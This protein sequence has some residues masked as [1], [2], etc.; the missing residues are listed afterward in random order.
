[1]RSLGKERKK[2]VGEVLAARLMKWNREVAS[3]LVLVAGAVLVLAF[4]LYYF[5]TL[6]RNELPCISPQCALDGFVSLRNGWGLLC[7]SV[8]K[9]LVGYVLVSFLLD[10]DAKV[11]CILKDYVEEGALLR[12]LRFLLSLVTSLCAVVI[13]LIMIE[14]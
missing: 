7:D 12:F 4:L 14:V 11:S 10:L 1:M 5:R 8:A 9:C 2:S 13:V 3:L 6:G